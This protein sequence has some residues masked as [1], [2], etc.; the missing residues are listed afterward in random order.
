MGEM[1]TGVKSRLKTS[2]NTDMEPWI[3]SM[4]NMGADGLV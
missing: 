2:E 4:E 3:Q 1:C